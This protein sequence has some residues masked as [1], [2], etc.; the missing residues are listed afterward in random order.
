MAEI[1]EAM[2]G[3]GKVLSYALPTAAGVGAGAALPGLLRKQKPNFSEE[4]KREFARH[5][6][7][8]GAL[9]FYRTLGNLMRGMKM[10]RQFMELAMQGRPSELPVETRGVG[11]MNQLGQYA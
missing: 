4:E 5:G 2:P 1:K 3:W 8:P 6:I 9:G 7:D 10:Q 11:G